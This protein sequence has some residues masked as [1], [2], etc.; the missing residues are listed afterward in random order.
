MLVDEKSS[1][2][3]YVGRFAPSPTG[4]LH[5]GSLVTALASYLDARACQGSWLVRMEDLDPPREE[6][7]A[8]SH[9][10][11]ALEAHH[12]HWDG[13]VLFQSQRLKDYA[14]AL[15]KLHP[16][17]Y[18]CDCSRQRIT[19]LGGGYDGHCRWF[20]SPKKRSAAL[21]IV[22]DALSSV[23]QHGLES[24]TDIFLGQQ[25]IS[26]KTTGDFILRRKDKFFAYQL[27]A[28]VDDGFQGI[29]HV[30]RGRDLLDSSSRQ[31]YLLT[32]L[33]HP[34]PCYGHV[35]LALGLDGFK[36][37]KQTRAD[38]IDNHR[39][40]KNLWQALQ[41]LNQS[42]PQDLASSSPRELLQ[43]GVAHWRRQRLPKKNT[44]AQL[45]TNK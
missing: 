19:A 26:L 18:H 32:L 4:K 20:P 13:S 34:L 36:L 38:T 2:K 27:A 37:S 29:T 15:R 16:Y 43:W 45:F 8:V 17:L 41:F 11:R 23:S 42:P 12:L 7:G 40:C 9:I 1:H 35:P 39:A 30:I 5:F 31:R 22:I 21:R 25:H 28:A 10:L 14:E 6:D 44:V 33:G 24:F 3:P